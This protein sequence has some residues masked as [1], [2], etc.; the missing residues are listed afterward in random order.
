MKRGLFAVS[1]CN[2]KIVSLDWF[3]PSATAMN[4]LSHVTYI[5]GI[6]NQSAFG[7][8]QEDRVFREKRVGPSRQKGGGVWGISE[9]IRILVRIGGVGES[10]QALRKIEGGRGLMVLPVPPQ[11][12]RGP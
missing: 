5:A 12:G 9:P 3:G 1:P 8:C 6:W 10:L 2:G 4:C 7:H 11:T